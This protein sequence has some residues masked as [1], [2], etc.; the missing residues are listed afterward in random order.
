MALYNKYRPT[1]LDMICGQ[2][3]VKRILTQQVKKGALSNSYL[4]IGPAGTGKT[5]LARVFAAMVNCSTGMNLNP[6]PEDRNVKIILSGK[7]ATDVLE[8]DAATNGKVEDMRALR[9]RVPYSPVEMSKRIWIIDECHKITDD[10]WQAL[11]K[12]LEEP[13]AHAM[14]IFCT[15]DPS[16]IPETILTRSMVLQLHS[17]SMK[18]ILVLLQ[19]VASSEGR[20]I[21]DDCL[22]MAASA[23]RGSM[24]QAL[25]NLDKMFLLDPCTPEEVTKVISVPSR[26][27]AKNFIRSTFKGEFA[28][29]L[30]ASSD[31]IASGVSAQEYIEEL[32]NFIHDIML[33]ETPNYDISQYGYSSDE[34]VEL[35][36][37]SKRMSEVFKDPVHVLL[38]Y[39]QILDAG[40]KLTAY[41]IQPQFHIDAVWVELYRE[42]KRNKIPKG[43]MPGEPDLRTIK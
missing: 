16:K 17:F 4:L 42:S 5:T 27:A 19:K 14:F 38:R 8:M 11:L 25:S 32:S 41:N 23:A 12:V 39:V 1:N 43:E 6:D 30:K 29:G 13:P 15:T 35:Q 36:A 37:I 2:E 40:H 9:D 21:S 10:G 33:C 20:N 34:V 3:H 22:K 18:D 26:A 28:M 7:G 24:R 31:V